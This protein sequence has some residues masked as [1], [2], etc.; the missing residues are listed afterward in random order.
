MSDQPAKID[1]RVEIVT[2]ENIAFSYRLAG[3][4][5]RLPAYL[6]DVFVRTAMLAAIGIASMITFGMAGVAQVGI[7]VWFVAWFG[8]SW[9]YGGLFEA[10]WNGQTPGK[11]LANIRVISVGG[12]PINF[13]QALLRNILRAADALPFYTYSFGLLAVSMNDRFQRLGD[14]ACGTMVVVESREAAGAVVRI[15]EP[16]VLQFAELLPHNFHVTPSLAR[17]LSSYVAR[18]PFM[19][20]SRR[21]EVSRYLA[22]PLAERLQ[23]P[24]ETNP[25]L[26]L[27]AL[28][29][30]TFFDDPSVAEDVG[31]SPFAPLPSAAGVTALEA[32]SNPFLT[33]T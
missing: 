17:A 18:R 22:G 28:Y 13:T 9:F 3:P 12:E 30:R 23:L 25:D 2:P 24:P 26:L 16:S 32:G 19:N 11:R 33:S 29:Q 21:Y 8:M 10:F 20:A 7:A 14:L 6:V 5:R 15:M 1:T 27:C 4:F 31:G